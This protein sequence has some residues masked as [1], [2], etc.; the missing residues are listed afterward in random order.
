MAL[1]KRFYRH[2][3]I[4]S[5]AVDECVKSVVNRQPAATCTYCH[6]ADSSL[7]VLKG[8]FSAYITAAVQSHRVS[9]LFCLAFRA[10]RAE[11][12]RACRQLRH[13]Y[14]ELHIRKPG[15]IIM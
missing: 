14:W 11:T 7:A 1:I 6:L 12:V 15:G 8:A 3:Y 5:P 10:L 4:L 2:V 13:H 9:F